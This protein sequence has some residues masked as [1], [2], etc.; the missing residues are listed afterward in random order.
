MN[1]QKNHLNRLRRL[2]DINYQ[3]LSSLTN[4]Q[5][6][7]IHS[8]ETDHATN[9]RNLIPFYNQT[10]EGLEEMAS[11]AA[12][13]DAASKFSPCH[14]E[15]HPY[16]L[17]VKE[18]NSKFYSIV[19]R[20]N[21]IVKFGYHN[22]DPLYG[23]MGLAQTSIA[24]EAYQDF[25]K[26]SY[27]WEKGAQSQL[28]SLDDITTLEEM[29]RFLHA[30]AVEKFTCHI[31][32]YGGTE[33]KQLISLGEGLTACISKFDNVSKAKDSGPESD[34]YRIFIQY[35]KSLN[36]HEKKTMFEKR[37]HPIHG[38]VGHDYGS[39]SITLGCHYTEIEA[40]FDEINH[41]YALKIR[42][43]DTEYSHAQERLNFTQ[44]VFDDLG[45]KVKR[46]E[47]V[48]H[49]YSRFTDREQAKHVFKEVLRFFTAS[50]DLDMGCYPEIC[51]RLFKEGITYL[52][53]EPLGQ[54]MGIINGDLDEKVEDYADIQI[55]HLPSKRSNELT[56]NYLFEFIDNNNIE[57]F[58]NGLVN[59]A[60]KKLEQHQQE[61]E[62]TMAENPSFHSGP[63]PFFSRA[64]PLK[65]FIANAQERGFDTSK[66]QPQLDSF[67]KDIRKY[68]KEKGFTAQK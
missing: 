57:D 65:V 20:L 13:I 8:L 1:H 49:S 40:Q 33:G 43:I 10:M 28:E 4:L 17:K 39:F 50:R 15:E 11:L 32:S 18:L 12:I 67:K 55:W 53:R 45:L 5:F 37:K 25:R 34:I 54:I 56:H 48:I 58:F 3:I 35:M 52:S 6:E 27:D 59:Y 63:K 19:E 21:F 68:I 31:T 29:V 22:H 2:K 62:K 61:I 14:I 38:I 26:L 47:K 44:K 42:Y 51:F 16:Y 60:R 7:A 46:D 41:D 64:R 24:Q 66:Y 30:Q 36:R 9:R 23:F